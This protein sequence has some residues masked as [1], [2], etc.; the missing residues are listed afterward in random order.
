LPK[1]FDQS[2]RENYRKQLDVSLSTKLTGDF[3]K[4]IFIINSIFRDF[5]LEI[6]N[7]S[8]G[9]SEDYFF[10]IHT[11]GKTAVLT[12]LQTTKMLEMDGVSL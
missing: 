10:G 9:V 12:P 8:D 4:D 6:S 2:Q 5:I 3:S 1:E 11:F 7:I